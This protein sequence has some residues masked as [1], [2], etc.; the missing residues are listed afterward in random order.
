MLC[1]R[2]SFTIF[3]LIFFKII[4]GCLHILTLIFK[5]SLI[6][7]TIMFISSKMLSL[8]DWM[9]IFHTH[10]MHP[11]QKFP[12]MLVLKFFDR[13]FTVY[14]YT[15][16]NFYFI[17]SVSCNVVLLFTKFY[18]LFTPEN[19]SHYLLALKGIVLNVYNAPPYSDREKQKVHAEESRT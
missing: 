15:Y 5:C 1:K 8:Y 2:H 17:Y 16:N 12:A 18:L 10:A 3:L 11:V 13:L 7:R 4:F 19:W 14:I 6:I 9:V